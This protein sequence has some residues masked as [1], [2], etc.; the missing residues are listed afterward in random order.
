MRPIQILA[1]TGTSLFVYGFAWGVKKGVL[2]ARDY[3]PALN[4][5]WNAVVTRALHPNGFLGYVRRIVPSSSR[6]SL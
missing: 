4:R 3:L 5:G 1:A 6:R 2:P